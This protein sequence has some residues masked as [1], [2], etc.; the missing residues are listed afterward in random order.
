MAS[1]ENNLLRQLQKEPGYAA[2]LAAA[3]DAIAYVCTKM[4]LGADNKASGKVRA[5]VSNRVVELNECVSNVKNPLLDISV[6][7]DPILPSNFIKAETAGCGNC[8][9][10]AAVALVYLFN[11]KYIRV[12][13]FMRRTDIDHDFVVIGRQ[14]GSDISNYTTWGA[15]CVVCDPWDEKAF[16]A[17][18]IA[19][20]AIKP[21][22]FAVRS[23]FSWPPPG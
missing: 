17:A 19:K 11:K 22:R 18:D 2:N 5:L 4:S 15:K 16:A 23:Q 14:A 12:V 6:A 10:Q 13:D 7:D 8:G 1:R 9:E 20:Y 3:Q 21:S